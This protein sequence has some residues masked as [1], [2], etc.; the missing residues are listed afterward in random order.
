MLAFLFVIMSTI[1]L[2]HNEI[3]KRNSKYKSTHKHDDIHD[4]A[5]LDSYS[6]IYDSSMEHSRV[7]TENSLLKPFL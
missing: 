3:H 4:F 1:D 2:G 7:S 5:A 6:V